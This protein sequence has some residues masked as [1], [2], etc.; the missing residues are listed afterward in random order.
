MSG[1]TINTAGSKKGF[2]TSTLSG[3]GGKWSGA[4]VVRPTTTST[5]NSI[6]STMNAIVNSGIDY[7]QSRGTG[8]ILNAGLKNASYADCSSAVSYAVQQATGISLSQTSTG[9]GVSFANAIEKTG[10]FM[11][12]F[13]YVDGTRTPLQPG[14]ILI[15]ANGGHTAVVLDGNPR[16]GS[17]DSLYTNADSSRGYTTNWADYEG[18]GGSGGTH[19]YR[20]RLVAPIIE[21][22]EEYLPEELIELIELGE[23]TKEELEEFYDMYFI[24][25]G[26]GGYS[27]F[28]NI[29]LTNKTYAYNR[30]AEILQQQ[31]SCPLGQGDPASWA[32]N[33]YGLTVD[34]A[35]EIGAAMCFTNTAGGAGF[36]CIVEM[37][38]AN[39]IL[40]T[41]QVI[42]GEFSIQNRQ[43]RYGAWDFDTYMFT[44]FVHNPATYMGAE[45]ETALETFLNIAEGAVGTDASWTLGQTSILSPNGWSGAFVTACSKRAGSS[46]NIVIPNVDSV[47][48]IG[49][50]GVLRGMGE[51]HKGPIYGGGYDPSAGDIA[52]FRYNN[53]G[54][55]S[56]YTGDKAA[57]VVE[58]DGGS[59]SG[60]MGDDGGHVTKKS[61]S[62]GS[63][64]IAGYF[65]PNWESI[66]GTTASKKE[67]RNIQGLYTNGVTKYDA[68]ARTAC[69]FNSDYKPSISP[70]KV[71]LGI[72][73]YTGLLANMYSVFG[74]A[75]IST[76]SN[77]EL[78][79]D[80][81]T[82]T[83]RSYYQIYE[84]DFSGVSGEVINLVSGISSGLT[85]V[86]DSTGGWYSDAE[87]IDVNVTAT[88]Q[89]VYDY[90][91][92][93]GLNSAAISGIL[94]NIQAESGFKTGAIGDSGT[95]AGLVQ[96]HAGRMQSMQAYLGSSWATNV[97]GQLD[98]IWKELNSSYK[99]V[100]N[101]LKNVPDTAEGAA[102]ATAKWIRSYEVPQGYDDPNS[103]VYT[104]RTGYAKGFYSQVGG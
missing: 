25:E 87:A 13:N 98:Y 84:G 39:E 61:Y 46:L 80:F 72:V 44:G 90:F 88:S 71:K 59:F 99:S 32:V 21:P 97:T 38:Y 19:E 57:I 63:D 23:I 92:A 89:Q 96:W 67:Y 76:A 9:N 35:P 85:P 49:R 31:G 24:Y 103:S 41:S 27:P 33:S 1:V 14:D 79:V 30:F 5:A 22:E 16:T 17:N 6:V 7:S 20:P 101:T 73:N 15:Y 12:T 10:A 42:D 86:T 78:V 69:Y 54:K 74:Q 34:M 28:G 11:Q 94:A 60:V 83:V 3:S 52:I 70:S 102:Q 91:A 50:V 93:K 4:I 66:D 47:S 100:L 104:T 29:P 40:I 82:N 51:W 68:C 26:R 64:Y 75:G 58:S 81:W 55:E 65:S 95:S 36:A 18:S 8:D 77:S 62:S 43:K 2:S 45:D 37:I 53:T 48:T 56:I